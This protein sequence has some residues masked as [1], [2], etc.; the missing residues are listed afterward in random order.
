MD[1]NHTYNSVLVA[2]KKNPTNIEIYS[3]AFSIL[4]AWALED[5]YSAFKRL[6][7]FREV[8]STCMKEAAKFKAYE[9]AEVLRDMLFRSYVL[10]AQDIFDD[11]CVAL[12]FDRPI[13]SQFYLP[14]R[15]IIKT[16]AD[17]LQD[18]ADDK[19]DELFLSCPPRIGK[20]TLLMFYQTWIMGRN[21]E[22][23][24]L[25]SSY[26]DIITG[27][28]YTGVMEILTDNNT[29][30]WQEIF[31]G[32]KIKRTNSAEET[33]DIN[34]KKHYPTLTCRSLYGTLNG[35]CDCN[36]SLIADDLI[37]GIEE[38][39]NKDRLMA[40]WQKV[41]NNLLAR[42]KETAKILWCGT[43]WSIMD[44]IGMRIDLMLNNSEYE[45]I[46]YKII[47]LPALNEKDESNFQ[48]MYNVGFSTDY[49]KRKRASFEAHNDTAS[50]VAQYMCEPIEREGTLF[51]ASDMRY[52]DGA[53]PEEEPD[54]VF[55]AVDPAFGGGDFV[56]SPVCMQYGNDIYVPAV[57]YDNSD[58]RITQPLLAKI[59]KKYGVQIMR[60]ECTKSTYSYAEGVR[61]YMDRH[62]YK[63]V[64][65]TKPAPTLL[66]KAIKI[67]EA[68]P[69]IR[70][71]F[72]FLDAKH[73]SSVYNAFMT[74]VFSFKKEGKNKHDDAPDSLA[75]AADMANNS[76]GKQVEI[77]ARPF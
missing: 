4:K 64:I 55:M 19:L 50:W 31:P 68:S 38:A 22:K 1:Y 43:R 24:N 60:I 9:D 25:Y 33:V 59:A 26:S 10:S 45:N 75:Q 56:A 37:G 34:R 77:V 8:T 30:K 2:L 57:V 6:P 18:L 76:F 47:N 70:D 67:Y 20:T 12:E 40:A 65:Q 49:Y 5:K 51:E 32:H 62:N 46:R 29:Y 66:S 23:S 11:Y 35:A 17:A 3:D 14:R 63:C 7:A 44:P 73:R 52:Y 54:R 53:L 72:I 71:K 69:D 16:F 74:N 27:S 42:A 58:K 39:L 41:D 61:K 13:Q 15:K 36:G 28:Y 48:Y 21:P